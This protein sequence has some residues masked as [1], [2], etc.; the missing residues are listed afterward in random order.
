MAIYQAPRKRWRLGVGAGVIG[1]LIGLVAGLVV[2][3]GSNDPLA[4]LR[5]LDTKLEDA[6]SPLD[7]LVIHGE[8]DT[9]SAGNPRVVTDAVARTKQRFDE[10][11]DA[12]SAINADA[13]E[14]FDEHVAALEELAREDGDSD[15]IADEAEE[16]AELLRGIIRA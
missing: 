5:D 4:S 8:A 2:G 14:E 9:G 13:V 15:D 11:R 12:V 16:L 6:A 7:V 10:V 1:V 3:G